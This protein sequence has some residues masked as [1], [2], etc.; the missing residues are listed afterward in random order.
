MST[1]KGQ[2]EECKYRSNFFVLLIGIINF[3]YRKMVSTLVAV[4]TAIFAGLVSDQPAAAAMVSA[5]C[6]IA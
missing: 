5:N 2:N 4:Y 6:N 3:C 1:A